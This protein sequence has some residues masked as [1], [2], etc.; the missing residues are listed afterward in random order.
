MNWSDW[1]KKLS[2]KGLIQPSI[3]PK[4]KKARNIK[5]AILGKVDGDI[6]KTIINGDVIIFNGPMYTSSQRKMLTSSFPALLDS[7]D[8]IVDIIEEQYDEK[9]KPY[10]TIIYQ[11]DNYQLVKF[12]TGKINTA[13]ITVIK[14]A[15]ILK[16]NLDAGRDTWA[17]KKQIQLR[18]G[19]RGAAICN[20][21]TS[22][23]FES[24]IKPTYEEMSLL[25]GFN[26]ERFTQVYEAIITNCPFAIFISSTNSFEDAKK[27]IVS[28]YE[29]A[30]N[31]KIK[32]IYVHGIGQD[33]I[34]KIVKTLTELVG[35]NQYQT[36]Q[37]GRSFKATVSVKE[38]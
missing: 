18:H 35:A 2:L 38:V 20:L 1:L 30:K 10:E 6:N 27:I 19:A 36:E 26:L 14:A 9:T 31:I 24:W 7:P 29:Q 28:K 25:P 5:V 3:L 12:F 4:L 8:Q 17:I 11:R 32:Y 34:K 33:N 22:G 23:Y 21:Y 37:S 15:Q 16:E 13:D